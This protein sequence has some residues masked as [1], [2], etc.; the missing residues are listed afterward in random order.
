VTERFI[1][2]LQDIIR[3]RTGETGAAATSSLLKNSD[4]TAARKAVAG[5]RANTA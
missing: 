4:A 5:F 2:E 3:I 1:T